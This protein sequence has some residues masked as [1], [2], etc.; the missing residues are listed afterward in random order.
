MKIT[1]RRNGYVWRG[2]SMG[3]DSSLERECHLFTSTQYT[4]GAKHWTHCTFTILYSSGTEILF[5]WNIV[6]RTILLLEYCNL[7]S[8]VYFDVPV[9]IQKLYIDIANLTPCVSEDISPILRWAPLFSIC[10]DLTDY[11]PSTTWPRF[12]HGGT[13]R[14]QMLLEA[15][16][17]A[18]A[19]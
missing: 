12:R 9:R 17:T 2:D 4:E 16:G 5:K 6:R 13:Y 14:H 3:R 15:N 8:N 19:W 7:T 10:A 11:T 18:C 1:G